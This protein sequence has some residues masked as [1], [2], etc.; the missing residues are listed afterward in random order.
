MEKVKPAIMKKDAPFQMH[1][2]PVYGILFTCL[3]ERE[4]MNYDEKQYTI[5]EE[6]LQL[7]TEQD[8][9]SLTKIM[10]LVWNKAMLAE[11]EAHLGA[12]HYEHKETRNGYANV[13]R[14]GQAPNCCYFCDKP[15]QFLLFNIQK[16]HA[17]LIR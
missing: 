4:T 16:G 3:K 11:R 5:I 7:L 2:P 10:S 9:Q 1:L 13:A 8:P 12:S 14:R 17:P 6:A 15:T